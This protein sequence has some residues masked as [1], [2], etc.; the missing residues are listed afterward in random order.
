M[1]LYVGN[2]GTGKGGGPVKTCHLCTPV[3]LMNTKR[4]C[5]CVCYLD[6]GRGHLPGLV[7]VEGHYM[8]EA[9]GI[10]IHRSGA[11]AKSLQD[12]VDCLPLLSCVNT[13]IKN[14]SHYLL[15]WGSV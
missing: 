1:L 6:G 2:K 5:A 3:S 10:G 9:A 14:V 4:V 11:V 12:G 13:K 15:F 7:E 8:G